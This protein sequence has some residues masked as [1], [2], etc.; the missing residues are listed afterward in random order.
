MVSSAIGNARPHPE[1]RACSNGSAKSNER[2]R[3][4]KDEDGHGASPPCFETHRSALGLWKRLRSSGCDAP[5]HEGRVRRASL[6]ERSQASEEPTCGCT[7]SP[8]AQ[9]PCFR[10][11]IYRERRNSNVSSRQRAVHRRREERDGEM[12]ALTPLRA[13]AA[14]RAR[15][16]DPRSPPVCR[17]RVRPA[18]GCRESRP[19]C[20]RWRA[21]R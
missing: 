1:E 21:R 3:V 4:S 16:D 8:P 13:R 10:P 17:N 7:K 9:F 20:S 18:A 5:Q 11:V 14:R 2:A 12:G 15:C 19:P 6:A